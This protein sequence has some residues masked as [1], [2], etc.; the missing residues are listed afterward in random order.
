MFGL[1]AIGWLAGCDKNRDLPDAESSSE[2]IEARPNEPGAVTD[3]DTLDDVGST[4]PAVSSGAPVPSVEPTTVPSTVP[5]EEFDDHPELHDVPGPGLKDVPLGNI[6]QVAPA[7][8]SPSPVVRA[9]TR[10]A[11]GGVQVT[12]GLSKEL[13]YRT[14]RRRM[15]PLQ[16]CYADHGDPAD[17]TPRKLAPSLV[18]APSGRVES[19]GN[20]S[21]ANAFEAC[22]ARYFEE[23]AF[24]PLDQADA[25]AT[26]V[27]ALPLQFAWR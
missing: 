15:L 1:L 24:P 7:G 12:G 27:V 23:L 8:S 4:Q 18:I 5:S 13:V 25:Q 16:R 19:V 20:L 22:V 21:E 11:L 3:T 9:T 26:Q 2:A 6:G 14:V 17:K 10:I